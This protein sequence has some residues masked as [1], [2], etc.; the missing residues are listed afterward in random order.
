MKIKEVIKMPQQIKVQ[1]P[2]CGNISYISSKGGTNEVIDLIC[3]HC[4]KHEVLV[5]YDLNMG[6]QGQPDGK[7]K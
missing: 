2:K 3:P 6:H 5:A 4:G 7:Q 1:C